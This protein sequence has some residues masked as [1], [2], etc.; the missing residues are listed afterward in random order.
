MM[1][2]GREPSEEGK[3]LQACV[4]GRS[5]RIVVVAAEDHPVYESVIYVVRDGAAAKGISAQEVLQEANNSLRGHTEHPEYEPLTEEAQQDAYRV[6]RVL[7]ALSGVAL[8]L[9]GGILAYW[10]FAF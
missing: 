9:S 4:K 10:F 6:S 7:F 2:E 1:R 8:A 5:R 3:P